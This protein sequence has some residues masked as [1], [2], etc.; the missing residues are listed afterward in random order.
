MTLTDSPEM[1]EALM[2]ALAPIRMSFINSAPDR[3]RE[4]NASLSA[5]GQGDD[6]NGALCGLRTEVHKIAGVAGSIGFPHLGEISAKADSALRGLIDG[7]PNAP[8]IERVLDQ[9][10]SI[11]NELTTIAEQTGG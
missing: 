8:E 7:D 1:S 10:D 2:A 5:I 11:L 6:V 9:I 3:V 4:I